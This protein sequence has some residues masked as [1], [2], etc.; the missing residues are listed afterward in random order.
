[1]L[2]TL[3]TLAKHY[4]FKH[5]IVMHVW[6]KTHLSKPYTS[7]TLKPALTNPNMEFLIIAYKGNYK[8]LLHQN[9]PSIS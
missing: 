8:T 3:I 5:L 1:M 6:R 4:D 2:L 7:K 9:R